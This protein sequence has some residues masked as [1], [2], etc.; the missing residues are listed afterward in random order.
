MK[1]ALLIALTC[2]FALSVSLSAADAGKPKKEPNEAQ[3]KV[4]K[5]MLEK[6]DADKDGK[7]SKEERA[8]ITPEDKEKLK[9]AGGN[10][11]E[12]KGKKQP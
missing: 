6:Y 4:M 9:S 8:K 2:M 7:L 11:G 5:E 10:K 1:K 12:K 3:K